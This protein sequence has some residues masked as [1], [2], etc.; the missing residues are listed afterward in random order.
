MRIGISLFQYLPGKVGGAGQYIE[1]LIY[2]L[3]EEMGMD[4]R[5]FLL[6]CHQNLAPFTQIDSDRVKHV[7]I[8]L[9]PLGVKI[10]RTLDLF[11]P[12]VFSRI[13][14]TAINRLHLDVTL[15][16]QQS[17]FPHGIQGKTVVTIVDFVHEHFPQ[18]FSKIDIAIRKTKEKYIFQASDAIIAISQQSL[19]DAVRLGAFHGK[20]KVIYLGSENSGEIDTSGAPLLESPYVVYP[21]N[22]YPHKNHVGL[23]QG[24]VEF[25]KKYPESSGVLVLTGQIAT[26]QVKRIIN[27]EDVKGHVKH[28]GYLKRADLNRLMQ[29]SDAMIFPSHFEGFGIPILE[30]MR[31]KKPIFCSNLPVFHEIA[32]DAV[33]YFDPF[34]IEDIANQ[35]EKIFVEGRLSVDENKYNKI[36]KEKNWKTCAEHTL[37][38]LREICAVQ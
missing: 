31:F 4:D 11:I 20:K 30:A 27:R 28:L 3:R 29:Y 16:P 5:L 22:D 13:F 37:V 17:I 33:E 12:D 36:L 15:Y 9:P 23:I 14:S 19:R 2:H 34:S 18:N 32:G 38:F 8:S 1:K 6:G 35:F 21:A 24:F 10:F 25:K 7:E 26:E